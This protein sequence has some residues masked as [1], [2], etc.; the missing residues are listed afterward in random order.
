MSLF[1]LILEFLLNLFA[2][3]PKDPP[4]K[5][6][7]PEQPNIEAKIYLEED[8]YL[9]YGRLTFDESTSKELFQLIGVMATTSVSEV[10][11]LGQISI[12]RGQNL[13]CLELDYNEFT[14]ES[15][16]YLCHALLSRKGQ[17]QAFGNLLAQEPTENIE[18]SEPSLFTASGET[19]E[20]IYHF[21]NVAPFPNLNNTSFLKQG[22]HIACYQTNNPTDGTVA[23]RCGFTVSQDGVVSSAGST[24]PIARVGKTYPLSDI[25]EYSPVDML[26]QEWVLSEQENTTYGLAQLETYQSAFITPDTGDQTDPE[27]PDGDDDDFFEF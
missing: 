11:G 17:F 4:Q 23:Y 26:R 8:P 6:P 13:S 24:D 1:L 7:Q 27:Q 25:A 3:G 20:L 12:R 21:L 5:E 15:P 10:P 19:A 22:E 18:A 14:G 9:D 16:K 2:F